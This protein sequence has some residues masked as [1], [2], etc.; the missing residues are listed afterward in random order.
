MIKVVNLVSLIM[1][2]IIVKYSQTPVASYL[3]AFVLLVAVGWAISRSKKAA[4][5]LMNKS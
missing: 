5:V 4:P 3:V 2:P 1:A